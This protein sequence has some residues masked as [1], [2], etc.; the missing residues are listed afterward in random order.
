MRISKF[1]LARLLVI[2]ALI[3]LAALS[4]V[5]QNPPPQAACQIVFNGPVTA[6]ATADLTSAATPLATG[7]G[8]MVMG[9]TAD[10]AWIAFDPGI[11][12]AGNLG[13]ARTR[14]VQ[15]SADISL[16]GSCDNLPPISPLPTNSSL[17]MMTFGQATPVYQQPDSAS[18][19][20]TTLTANDT[21]MIVGQVASGWYAWSDP[22]ASAGATGTILLHWIKNSDQVQLI[23]DCAALP[24][25]YPLPVSSSE[26]CTV[27]TGNNANVYT[28]P[29][30]S[31]ASQPLPGMLV[32]ALART[33]GW[34]G[35]DP[36]GQDTTTI[37]I[38]RL[39]WIQDSAVDQTH[40]DCTTLPL[41][42]PTPIALTVDDSGTAVSAVVGDTITLQLPGNPSLG[43]WVVD[44]TTDPYILQPQGAPVAG[45]DAD[46]FGGRGMY[47]LTFQAVGAG[48]TP[49]T[50]T[51]QPAPASDATPA[52]TSGGSLLG[53]PAPLPT[54]VSAGVNVIDRTHD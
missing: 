27:L 45:T 5:A 48:E 47:T 16:Q 6:Y 54:H 46:R 3:A 52:P 43:Q 12:Q 1:R 39:R 18:Q 49:L 11:A 42:D 50:L 19:I 14:W 34:F 25:F 21:A 41:V 33:A 10:N 2:G 23:G 13:V 20:T 36:A 17:C 9:E 30:T 37:G 22:G 15:A 8:G 32:E 38:N 24:T 40:G 29:E 4:A 35:Y 53:T 51:F 44:A 26:P 31:A 7:D 28:M